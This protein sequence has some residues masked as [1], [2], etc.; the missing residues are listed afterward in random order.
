MEVDG[1]R[2][3]SGKVSC[4]LAANV[5]KILGGV[6]AFPDAQPNDG[7]LELGVVTARNPVQWARTFGRLARGQAARVPLRQGHAGEGVQDP[8]RP[9]GPLRARRRRA[10]G[11][12]EAAHQGPSGSVTVCVPPGAANKRGGRSP[13]TPRTAGAP[14]QAGASGYSH[15]CRCEWCPLLPVVSIRSPQQTWLFFT[16]TGFPGGDK[17]DDFIL[18]PPEAGVPAA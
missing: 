16:A 8:V 11:Q 2:F 17:E 4:V 1:T 3:F 12:Q 9:E 15:V 7:R 14:G 5:G 13:R 10:P 6:E 18:L